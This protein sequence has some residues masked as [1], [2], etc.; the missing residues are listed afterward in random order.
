MRNGKKK[1]HY[2]R[3][4]KA[5]VPVVDSPVKGNGLSVFKQ[6]AIGR[7]LEVLIKKE[8]DRNMGAQYQAAGRVSVLIITSDNVNHISEVR[9][10][11]WRNFR[12]SCEKLTGHGN[13]EGTLKYNLSEF[14]STSI[15]SI[16]ARYTELFPKGTKK[17]NTIS[18]IAEPVVIPKV[19]KKV[20][21]PK[22]EMMKKESVTVGLSQFLSSFLCSEKKILNPVHSS[23]HCKLKDFL[24]Y[25]KEMIGKNHVLNCYSEATAIKV[26]AAINWRLGTEFVVREG[27]DVMVDLSLWKDR[28]KVSN[29]IS[30]SMPPNDNSTSREIVYRL[31]RVDHGAKPLSVIE[32]KDL[33]LVTYSQ[34][35]TGGSVMDIIIGMGWIAGIDSIGRLLVYKPKSKS[36]TIPSDIP[37]SF[38]NPLPFALIT[39][40]DKDEASVSEPSLTESIQ[41]VNEQVTSSP[42]D[43]S[44]RLSSYIFPGLPMSFL[45]KLKT[46]EELYLE[47]EKVYNNQPFFSKLKEE[48]QQQIIEVIEQGYAEAH[49]NEYVEMLLELL[50]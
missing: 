35:P 40:S 18:A 32:E 13:I 31:N 8:L 6:K 12:V 26:E 5:G 34:K 4:V 39:L 21:N 43:Q 10:Y 14:D 11:L 25:S 23:E 15:E 37:S 19:I 28:E 45:K 22:S 50:K 9:T 42:A 3:D 1:K 2:Q 41:P 48:N 30:F 17:V 20:T 27:K 7:K 16:N 46:R 24:S 44:S 38:P 49:P 29:S 36:E 33:F 47:V